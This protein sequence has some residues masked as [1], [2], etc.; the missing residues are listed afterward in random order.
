M[1]KSLL[2]EAVS[3]GAF[4]SITY[5][6]G[7]IVMMSY[8]L[9]SRMSEAWIVIL[10]LF[11]TF[12]NH[13]YFYFT[14]R[15]SIWK[16]IFLTTFGIL[17]IS[18]FYLGGA[19]S[20]GVLWAM[21]FPFFAF[22]L[23][24]YKKAFFIN[25]VYIFSLIVVTIFKT[26]IG[27]LIH[28]IEFMIF[29]LF[30]LIIL[31]FLTHKYDRDKAKLIEQMAQTSEKYSLLF[32]HFNQAILVVSHRLEMLEINKVFERWFG[33]NTD[34]VLKCLNESK[35]SSNGF[36]VEAA[37][38]ERKAKTFLGDFTC[39]G[40]TR[41]FRVVATPIFAEGGVNTSV[42]LTFEDVT[43]QAKQYEQTLEK[44]VHFESLANLDAL[45]S[46]YNRRYFEEQT[47]LL[48]EMASKYKQPLAILLIDI[49]LF[50]DY[51]DTLGHMQGD[52]ALRKVSEVLKRE[53]HLRPDSFVARYGGEELVCVLNDMNIHQAKIYAQK[54]H[55]LIEGLNIPH[56]NSN[57]KPYLTVS[58]GVSSAHVH[59]HLTYQRIFE[60]ADSALYFAKRHGRNQ[61][62]SYHETK[63]FLSSKNP[64]PVI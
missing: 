39:L 11:L 60:Q 15:F 14:K 53:V 10:A 46:L 4:S 31:V 64:R 20:N 54:L 41:R 24:G 25:L 62:I 7:I 52:E 32:R 8:Y 21:F 59:A 61:V 35:H 45:T 49:D 47:Q 50:K 18:S 44:A 27:T 42:M 9:E 30:V 38:Q 29:Y 17:S 33:T 19:F 48:F 12:C 37:L 55:S 43:E 16:R 40:S 34:E 56:P 1:K 23:L 58:I 13:V 28:P 36:I 22:Y 2:A 26:W 6:S 51:N 5:I 63:S 3:V 57:V